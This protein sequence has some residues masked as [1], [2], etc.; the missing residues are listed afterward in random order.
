M[1]P[2]RVGVREFRGNMTAFLD[3]ARQGASILITSHDR[4]VA[5]LG[6]PPAS[7]LPPRTPGAMKGKIWISPDYDPSEGVE[8][9]EFWNADHL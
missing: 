8:L 1:L 5:A 2:K 3:A 7:E 6:P 4:V 9:A